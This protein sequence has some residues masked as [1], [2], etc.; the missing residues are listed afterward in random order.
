MSY[1]FNFGSMDLSGATRTEPKAFRIALLGDFSA[2][3][4]RGEQES[5]ADLAGRK[6]HRVDIDNIDDVLER[7]G[8]SLSIPVGGGDDRVELEIGSM[9]DLHPDE[10]FDNVEVFAELASLRRKLDSAKWEAAAKDL[11]GWA[12]DAGK[13]KKKKKPKARG[14]AIPNARLSGF[15]ELMSR[16]TGADRGA[17]TVDALVRSVV[18]PHAVASRD[19]AQDELITMADEALSGLM[20]DILHNP[21]FQT[22]ESLWRSVDLLTRRLETGKD[23]QIVL[24]DMTAEELATDLAEGE[25]LSETGLYSMLVE[26]PVQDA[27]QGPLSLIVG[28]Y[29][30]EQTPPHAELL[31][32]MAKIAAAANAPFLSGI[33][34][35]VIRKPNPDDDHPLVT[36][37]WKALR[38]LPEAGYVGLACPRFMLRNPYGQKTDPIDPF[39]FEEFTMKGG[40]G[41]MLWGNGAVLATM[42]IAESFK[43][44]KKISALRL[45]SV[46]AVGD[47]PYH[48]FTDE[49]GDQVALPCTNRLLSEKS[50]AWVT[51]QGYI[52]VLSVRGAPEARIGGFISLTGKTLAGPWSDPASL[53]KPEEKASGNAATEEPEDEEDTGT[54]D[55]DDSSDDGDDDLDALLASLE[56]DDDDSGSGDSDSD[57][58]DDDEMDA[59]LAALLAE[60]D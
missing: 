38:G 41:G 57:D 40:V 8:I 53:P 10:L 19:A 50:M 24:Y 42:M 32:R 9:D 31:G 59:E 16:P 44:A 13:V 14:S 7:M 43:K 52:P 47:M 45:G 49:H 27:Q 5:G 60:L 3:A 55:T 6:P 22:V 26:K 33:S 21:D 56:D 4:N 25:D 2:R 17:S 58:D 29:D 39:K 28:L 20:R 36:E 11:Q 54:D 35:D 23:L 12:K 37:S 15:G 48:Y 30:F 18:G 46:S 34:N 1:E 51:G